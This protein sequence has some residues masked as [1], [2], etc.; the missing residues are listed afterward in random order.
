MKYDINEEK[1]VLS[2]REFVSIARRS[3]SATASFDEDE[4]SLSEI[5][6]KRLEA[7]VGPIEPYGFSEDFSA[8]GYDFRLILRADCVRGDEIILAGNAVSYKAEPS[9]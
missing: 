6:A 9:R 2:Q 1:I 4:P 5:S 8:L 7:I 3:V